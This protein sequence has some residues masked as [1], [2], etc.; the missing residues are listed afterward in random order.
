MN[1]DAVSL[2]RLHDILMPAPVPW[3][4]PAPGWY[5]V[6]AM[7][8]V[9]AL[10]AL[11]KGLA[12]WQRNRYR[13]EALAE[14]ARWQAALKTPALRA[15]ALL[16]L[17][18]LLKRTALTAFGRPSVAPL[19]GPGW[20]AFLDRTA[21]GSGFGGGLG[22]R[23]EQA[24]YDPRAAGALDPQHLEALVRAIRQWIK[25]H[26]SRLPSATADAAPAPPSPVSNPC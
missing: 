24:L 12:S 22:P 15:P 13:R 10:T 5:W 4:P 23:W 2:D 9:V 21:R 8:V 11:V 19:T 7:V 3:W 16:G 26:D 18:E 17:A 1:S 20:F 6:L 14:L 25:G